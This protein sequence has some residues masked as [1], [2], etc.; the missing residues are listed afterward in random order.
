MTPSLPTACPAGHSATLDERQ[1][2]LASSGVFVERSKEVRVPERDKVEQLLGAINAK[3]NA[4]RAEIA[5]SIT[6]GRLVWRVKDGQVQV[7]LDLTL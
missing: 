5:K 4:N 2:T 1:V 6:Y 7:H 3:L